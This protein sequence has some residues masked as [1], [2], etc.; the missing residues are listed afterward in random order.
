MTSSDELAVRLK[1]GISFENAD[2]SVRPQD[3]LYRFMNGMYIKNHEIPADRAVDGAFNTLRIKAEK[4]VMDIIDELSKV[5]QPEGSTAKKIGDLYRSFMDEDRIEKLGLSPIAADIATVLSIKNPEEF[6]EHMGEFETRGAGGLFYF[7]VYGD[8]Q[9]STT[10]IGYTGQS[11]ISLPDEAYYREEEYEPIRAAFLL[12]MQNMF[13]LAGIDDPHGHSARVL[14][15]ETE[16]ASHHWDQVKCR[17]AVLTYNKKSYQELQDLSKGFDWPRYLNAAKLPESAVEKVIVSQPSFFTGLGSMMEKFEVEK[18]RSW[19]LWHLI[20]GSAPYLHKALVD[21]NFEFYGKVL[22]GIPQI[23]ERWKR[24]VS[25]VE[26]VLGEAIGEIYVSKHFPPAAKKRMDVLVANLIEAYRISITNL[27]WMSDETKK[28]ALAKLEKFTPKIGYPDKWRDYSKLEI[29]P[30]DLIGN[31]ASTTKFVMDYELEKIGKPVDKSEW[32]MTPQT[33]NAYYMPL[34]NEIVFPAAMLQKPFFDLEADDATNYGAIGVIIGHEIGHGFDDQGSKFDGDGNLMDWWID[35]DRVE[36]E[37]RAEKLIEQFNQLSPEGIPDA[38]VNGAL[39]IGE[40][41]GD[42]GGLTIAYKAYEIALN[43][44]QAPIID[45]LTGAERF[46][47]SFA[48]SWCGKVREEEARRRLQVDPHSPP[49]FRVNQIIKNF[50]LFYETFNVS[51]GDKLYLAPE[52]RV[53]I[54]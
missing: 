47:Y 21:E 36:F 10:N 29:S 45:G 31:I 6:I 52:E 2:K 9:D 5:E 4:E 32:L 7:V 20:S 37:K 54:W 11:G 16:I 15:L 38:K 26:G 25:I 24:G 53:T 19:L 13:N 33:V 14:A 51:P 48:Q 49:E 22:S 35:F 44:Q 1:S 27:D 41:I 8:A 46:F 23:R 30:D 18:W 34:N 3:D 40:N 28:K 50:D 12:H 42:L 39:T 43:G 17:D